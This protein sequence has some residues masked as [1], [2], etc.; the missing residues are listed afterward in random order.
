MTRVVLDT[1]VL[2]SGLGWGGPPARIIEA[3]VDGRLVLITSPALLE[4][5]RRVLAYPRLAVAL[6]DPQTLAG[7]VED[8]GVV[9]DTAGRVV[10]ASRDE[11]DNRVLEAATAG[12]ADY[13][14]SGDDD[15]LALGAFEGIA[16][17]GPAAFV[18]TVLAE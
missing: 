18:G 3:V 9:V 7:L 11:A 13:V 15:L 14:V 17:A 8:I 4:E 16:I 1:N 12:A 10:S 5:F 2:V 6:P